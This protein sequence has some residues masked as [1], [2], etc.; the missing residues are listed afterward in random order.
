M[1]KILGPAVPFILPKR[2]HVM[3]CLVP[4]DPLG[5]SSA[6]EMMKTHDIAFSNRPRSIA[7][8]ILLCD[9]KD[10]G[11][12]EYGEYWRQLRKICV[13]EPSRIKE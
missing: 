13:L 7:T 5:I 8:K 1:P 9:G 12:A 2:D 3:P 11:F 10:L 6:S 4:P